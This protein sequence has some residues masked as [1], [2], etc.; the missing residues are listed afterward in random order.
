MDSDD[1]DVRRRVVIRGRGAVSQPPGR[2]ASE[3]RTRCGE[4][5]F[6]D[7]A[8]EPPTRTRTSDEVARR[9]INRN[10]SP[11]IFFSLSVNP[12]RGCEHG[13]TYCYARAGH[14]YLGLSPGLDF[15]TRLSAKRNAA[16]CLR[17]ELAARAY[18]CEP[19]CIGTATDCYQPIERGLRITREII[20]TLV[21]C[22]HPFSLITKSALVERDLDLIASAARDGT[23][24]VYV[25]VTCLDPALARAWEPRAAAPWRRIETIRRLADAGVPVGV[26]VAPIAPFLNDG[27]IEAVLEAAARAGARSAHYTILRLPDELLTVFTDWLRERFPDRA[28]RVMARIRDLRAGRMN[29]PR[30]HGRMRGEGVWADLIA[31]RFALAARRQG[32]VTDRAELRED[33]FVPPTR[34]PARSCD[35]S[36]AS[37]F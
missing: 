32:L 7:G 10:D 21:G 17:R 13:C 29:D 14:A 16:Q 27:D 11:D 30:F 36:Q 34:E 18:R 8:V 22:R 4:P 12:Y 5:D 24:A 19:L 35:D 31:R 26:M 25:T 1:A 2:F 20:E 9:I 37:L 23:A 15:E 28:E 3:S 6:D 33:L